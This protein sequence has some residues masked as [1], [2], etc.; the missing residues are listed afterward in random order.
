MER[1]FFF[2]HPAGRNAYVWGLVHLEGELVVSGRIRRWCGVKRVWGVGFG[3][4]WWGAIVSMW[5][6]SF[7]DVGASDFRLMRGR[8]K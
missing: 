3:A 4:F 6:S 2:A 1:V 5:E 7:V 8:R